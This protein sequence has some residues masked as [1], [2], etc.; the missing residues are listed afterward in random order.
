MS[1][2]LP[3]IKRQLEA[4]IGSLSSPELNLAV[5][6]IVYNDEITLLPIHQDSQMNDEQ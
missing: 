5:G 1:G 2:S 4:T 3:I 6:A